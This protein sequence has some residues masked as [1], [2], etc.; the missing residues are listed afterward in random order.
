MVYRIKHFDRV[1][2]GFKISGNPV[3][4]DHAL[5]EIPLDD[6]TKDLLQPDTQTSELQSAVVVGQNTNRE[7]KVG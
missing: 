4:H 5:G 7:P 6:H 1:A 2:S 3:A